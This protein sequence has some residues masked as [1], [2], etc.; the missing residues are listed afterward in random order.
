MILSNVLIIMFLLN[1]DIVPFRSP[2]VYF[3]KYSLPDFLRVLS[4]LCKSLPRYGSD[5]CKF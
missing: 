5:L 3:F 2:F 1:H 4:V